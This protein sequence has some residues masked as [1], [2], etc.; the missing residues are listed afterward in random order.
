LDKYND[1]RVWRSF[2]FLLRL[3]EMPFPGL[4]RDGPPKARLRRL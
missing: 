4:L 3:A 2:L 1:T